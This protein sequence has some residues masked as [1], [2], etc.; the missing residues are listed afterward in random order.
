MIG[1]KHYAITRDVT[2]SGAKPRQQFWS[3]RGNQ[4]R[5]S[6]WTF[7]LSSARMYRTAGNAKSAATQI[8]KDPGDCVEVVEIHMVVAKVHYRIETHALIPAHPDDLGSP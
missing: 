6:G 3:R 5:R 8:A 7:D 1:Q 2:V 4:H